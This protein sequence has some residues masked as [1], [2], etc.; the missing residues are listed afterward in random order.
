M[1]FRVYFV[2][3]E[4]QVFRPFV[5]LE[6]IH[7]NDELPALVGADPGVVALVQLREVVEEI[8]AS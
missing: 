7:I 2:D 6:R 8:L 4:A 3:D 1:Q 5:E